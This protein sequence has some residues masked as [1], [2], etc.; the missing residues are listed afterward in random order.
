[1]AL[2]MTTT[3]RVTS[4]LGAGTGTY[5]AVDQVMID[6]LIASV[7][8]RLEA[9][10]DRLTLSAA[11]TEYYDQTPGMKS[12]QLRAYPVSTITLL[13]Y[14]R[15]WDFTTAKE[16]L[17]TPA[18]YV[19]DAD[20]G[21]VYLTKWREASPRSWKVTY[22]GGMAAD[23]TALIA[24]YPELADAADKQVVHEWLRRTKLEALTASMQGP[25]EGY[26][27]AVD[28]LPVVKQA[29]EGLRRF[30]WMV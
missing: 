25:Q 6:N 28:L 12:I 13:E 19:F 27:M 22:T 26:P 16:T 3:A 18:D 29:V 11:R 21:I 1:M 4:I 9:Y 5:A 14:S 17:A 30:Q 24:A 2:L 7:S 20:T 8:N 23:T 15:T 10:L